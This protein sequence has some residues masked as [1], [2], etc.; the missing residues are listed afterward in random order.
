M[1]FTELQIVPNSGGEMAQ[2][3]HV[4]RIALGEEQ[5][6]I[7]SFPETKLMRIYNSNLGIPALSGLKDDL[8]SHAFI[9]HH[10]FIYTH[11]HAYD[12]K[13]VHINL[14]SLFTFVQI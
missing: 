9:H 14:L 10:T 3:L 1:N 7:P 4:T 2:L 13:Q 5:D 11:T 6:T 8:H 12:Y